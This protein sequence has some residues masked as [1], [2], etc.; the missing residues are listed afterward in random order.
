ME[1]S[2]REQENGLKE[3]Q[4]WESGD[5]A[6]ACDEM[7]K[8]NNDFRTKLLPKVKGAANVP[9]TSQ[10]GPFPTTGPDIIIGAGSGVLVEAVSH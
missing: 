2:A 4:L 5:Y 3:Q 7:N 10:T 9:G 8:N 1:E 6:A